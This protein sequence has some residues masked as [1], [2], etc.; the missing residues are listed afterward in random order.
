MLSTAIDPTARNSDCQFCRVRDQKSG[1]VRYFVHDSGSWTCC[2]RVS[3]LAAHPPMDCTNQHTRNISPTTRVSDHEYTFVRTPPARAHAG[4][5]SS[6]YRPTFWSWS[7]SRPDS[8]TALDS[9]EP[10]CTN[11]TVAAMYSRN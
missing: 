1:S 10:R 3:L 5:S 8:S 6:A 2:S 9:G 11:Q 4:D 7:L